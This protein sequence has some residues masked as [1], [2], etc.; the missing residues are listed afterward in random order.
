ML[1]RRRALWTG[2]SGLLVAGCGGQTARTVAGDPKDLRVLAAALQVE[3]EQIAFYE[4]GSRLSDV[5]LVTTILEHER[6]HAAALREAIID[7]GG[8][9]PGG[10][11]SAGFALGRGFDAWRREA[12]QREE[13]WSA[14]YAA[15]IPKLAS[16][17]LRATFGALMTTEAEHAAALGLAA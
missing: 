2:A 5:R 12:V 6:A 10:R 4:A 13:R 9:P 15:L 17:Q 16:V 7:L 11:A 14:G 8:K 3:R 1:T